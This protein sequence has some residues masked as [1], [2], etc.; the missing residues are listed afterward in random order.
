MDAGTFP[1][2][3]RAIEPYFKDL[4]DAGGRGYGM[5]RLRIIGLDAEAA[6][7]D[8]TSGV[9]THRGAIFGMGLLC[10][11]A[12]ARANGQMDPASSLGAIVSRLWVTAFS[13]APYFCTVM[14]APPVVAMVPAAHAWRPPADFQAYMKSDCPRCGGAPLWLQTTPKPRASNHASRSSPLSKTLICFI[15]AVPQVS[16]LHAARLKSFSTRVAS[17]GPIGE[18]MRNL[19]TRT[20]CEALAQPKR[21]RRSPGDDA[22]CGSLR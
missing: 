5:G 14:A 22:L 20:L 18:S 7:R 3:A 10:A 13:T 8:V 12:G 4:A 19:C 6:M 15:A 11:A 16:C 17:A 21:V 2:S 1:R 9:N